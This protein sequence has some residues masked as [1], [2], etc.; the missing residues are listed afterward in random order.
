VSELARWGNLWP[1]LV[2]GITLAPLTETQTY[3]CS[4][5]GYVVPADVPTSDASGRRADLG[6]LL[7]PVENGGAEL[8]I[9]NPSAVVRKSAPADGE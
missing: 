9:R 7:F 2:W 8:L 5:V 6:F 3:P 1:E 4:P